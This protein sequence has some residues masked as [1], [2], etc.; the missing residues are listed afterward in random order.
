MSFLFPR[1][2][3]AATL[4]LA[5]L[6]LSSD[7]SDSRAHWVDVDGD[8]RLDL[9]VSSASGTRLFRTL[10]EGGHED[11]TVA[12]GLDPERGARASLWADVDA[13]GDPDLFQVAAP[14]RLWLNEDGRL[15]DETQRLGLAHEGVDLDAAWV[16]IDADGRPDLWIAQAGR[17]LVYGRRADGTFEVSHLEVPFARETRLD[18]GRLAD[19][20]AQ[21]GRG[22]E[23]PAPDG[24]RVRGL[25]DQPGVGSQPEKRIRVGSSGGP[26]APPGGDLGAAPIC[27]GELRD[28]ATGGCIEASSVPALGTLLPLGPEFMVDPTGLVG[29]GTLAPEHPVHIVRVGDVP[30]LVVSGGNQSAEIM[31]EADANDAGESNQPSLALSQDGGQTVGRLGF[32]NG[33][34]NLS[35]AHESGGSR[36]V[37]ANGKSLRY[38]DD[39]LGVDVFTFGS[40]V[41]GGG[42][43]VGRN[44]AGDDMFALDTE[45]ADGGARLR[46]WNGLTSD[47][48]VNLQTRE[49]GGQ[50]AELRMKTDS[51]EK[52]IELDAE[53][54]AGGGGA[55]FLSRNDGAET[56]VLRAQ[57]AQDEGAL[58][59]LRT[60]DGTS[61]IELD[62]EYNNGG[63]GRI[64]VAASDG[65]E[66]IALRGQANPA[67]GAEMRLRTDENV[68]TIE[69]D[70]EWNN[71]G[72]GRIAVS[73]PSGAETIILNGE[74]GRTRTK[75]LQITGG[76]DIAEPFEV[77]GESE[78]VAGS[79][80]SIDPEVP[81]GLRLAHSAYDETVVGVISGAGGIRPGLTLTQEGSIADGTWPVALSGRVYVRADA[82]SGAIRPGDFLT[83]SPHEGYAMKASDVVR[84]QGAV[85][86][87]AM[88]ALDEGTGLVL[89]LVNLQ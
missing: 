55:L 68:S 57:T 44:D 2:G 15:F 24:S 83:T 41:H 46:L 45:Q 21:S 63:G 14:S 80:V 69:F 67:Q 8:G 51:G 71:G 48:A 62:G 85:I 22:E 56:V 73:D 75:V 18:T 20:G 59:R 53:Y 19:D 40:E 84:R 58:L 86:G 47:P 12:A 70:A 34:N 77:R 7:R 82:R 52:T 49:S 5:S 65:V 35:L 38:R 3:L 61:T 88:S 50:G 29:I 43:F 37:I 54:N 23:V 64:V 30:Q 78:V 31:I 72:G 27:A 9:F 32:F 17:S 89:V 60:D 76:S 16:D 25:R 10:P 74:L 33:N 4:G 13:D 87:K 1:T 26:P 81:G 66:T 42:Q 11:V 36:V 79:V 39:E 6:F 28:V